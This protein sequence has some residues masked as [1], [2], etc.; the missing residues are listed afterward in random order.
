MLA[1]A[2]AAALVATLVA[3]PVVAGR[4][5]PAVAPAD[6]LGAAVMV[7]VRWLAM[8]VAVARV[9]VGAN[10]AAWRRDPEAA[11]QQGDEEEFLHE[12]LCV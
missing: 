4:A 9:T 2:V 3:V 10:D 5:V 11:E 6:R 1:R 7:P 8:H 12:S